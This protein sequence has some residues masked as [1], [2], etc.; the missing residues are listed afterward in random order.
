MDSGHVYFNV[1]ESSRSSAILVDRSC[2]YPPSFTTGAVVKWDHSS[3]A[4]LHC[5]FDSRLLHLL[6]LGLL[7][8]K[9]DMVLRRIKAKNLRHGDII[10]GQRIRAIH[11]HI[12]RDSRHRKGVS[13]TYAICRM[14]CGTALEMYQFDDNDF[15]LVKRPKYN[16]RKKVA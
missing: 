2:P 6:T 5:G 3:M 7:T 1:I 12:G 13:R 15:V 8:R 10:N 11:K 14:K 4:Y 9:I 16:I